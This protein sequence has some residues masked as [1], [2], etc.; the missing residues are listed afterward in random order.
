MFDS[1]YA[2]KDGHAFKVSSLRRERNSGEFGTSASRSN[3]HQTSEDS[4]RTERSLNITPRWVGSSLRGPRTPLED[5][6]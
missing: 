4:K 2:K 3:K 5:D 6:R 1:A